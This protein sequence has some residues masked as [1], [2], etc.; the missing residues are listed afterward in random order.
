MA[1][2]TPREALFAFLS[3]DNTVMATVKNIHSRRV[4]LGAYKPLVVIY[5]TIS[6]V[7][8]RDL[9]GIAYRQARLQV[10]VMADTQK[11]A[12]TTIRAIIKAV[13]G[14]SGSMFG[15]SVIQALAETDRQIDEDE[16]D[17]VHQ[18]LDVIIKY[19]E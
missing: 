17:E 18:H 6:D 13:D 19:E 1:E 15:L 7:P 10:T 2:I 14:F 9:S 5:P 12:E 4:P 16:V 8:T 3:T 11:E